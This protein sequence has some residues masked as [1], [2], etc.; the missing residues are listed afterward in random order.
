VQR[1]NKSEGSAPHDGNAAKA[2][3]ADIAA[4]TTAIA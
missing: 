1:N 3:T 2:T 4:E